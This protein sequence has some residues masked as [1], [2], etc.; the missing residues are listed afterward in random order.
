[1]HLFTFFPK[2]IIFWV[3]ITLHYTHDMRREKCLHKDLKL[4]K[5]PVVKSSTEHSKK[6]FQKVFCSVIFTNESAKLR[7]L[8]VG[9][10][11][12]MPHEFRALRDLVSHMVR[13]FHALVS[14]TTSCCTSCILCF[15]CSLASCVLRNAYILCFMSYASFTFFS[16]W[17]LPKSFLKDS[18]IK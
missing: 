16:I 13:V 17:F 2:T 9:S 7:T 4:Q 8:P 5:P 18:S 6:N 10:P 1:M 14:I 15:T 11:P 3:I 12:F